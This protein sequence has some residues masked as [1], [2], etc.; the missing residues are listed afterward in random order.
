MSSIV[1]E[2][3]N[4]KR[5]QGFDGIKGRPSHREPLMSSDNNT[6]STPATS[7]EAAGESIKESASSVAETLNE[8]TGWAAVCIH[9]K[10]PEYYYIN[11]LSHRPL[12]FLGVIQ[13][14]L[15]KFSLIT[16]EAD[17]YESE[18]EKEYYHNFVNSLVDRYLRQTPS[19]I[20]YLPFAELLNNI[21]YG[22]EGT[23]TCEQ[24]VTTISGTNANSIASCIMAASKANKKG[25]VQGLFNLP[26]LIMSEL[27][28]YVEILISILLRE[29]WATILQKI[30]LITLMEVL[31]MPLRVTSLKLFLQ[32]VSRI[33]NGS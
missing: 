3:T 6:S 13:T 23:G 2:W 31:F 11:H 16:P 24:C 18:R 28:D 21:R 20:E 33:A 9:K 30:S 25:L 22:P 29:H 27:E 26:E 4:Y 14:Y 32:P 8:I 10:A 12:F 15:F 19:L 17:V 1:S 5:S 7:F